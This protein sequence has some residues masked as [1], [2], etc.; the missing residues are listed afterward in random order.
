[1]NIKQKLTSR[2]FWISLIAVISGVAQILGADD[3]VTALIG[4]AITLIPSVIYVITE[5]R[6][7]AKKL[8]QAAKSLTDI[9]DSKE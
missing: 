1:M 3:S 9:F 4:A 7:D 8:T 2:K 6:L 5:G